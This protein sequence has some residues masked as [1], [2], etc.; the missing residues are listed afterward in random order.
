[1][2]LG[3]K[4]AVKPGLYSFNDVLDDVCTKLMDKQA[5]YSVRRILEMEESLGVLEQE[6]EEFLARKTRK[7]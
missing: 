2:V 7:L 5:K 6:L 4:P 3:E 1:M